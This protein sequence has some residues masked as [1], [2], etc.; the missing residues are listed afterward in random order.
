MEPIDFVNLL[1]S[2]FMLAGVYAAIV[3]GG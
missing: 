2:A 3:G 1:I